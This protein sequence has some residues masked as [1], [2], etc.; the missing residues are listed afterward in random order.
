M[1][2][3]RNFW[4]ELDVDGRKSNIATGPRS[5][6]GGFKLIVKMKKNGKISNKIFTLEGCEISGKFLRLVGKWNDETTPRIDII[7]EK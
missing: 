7:T 4:L 6:N 5:L 2:N 3:I 1:R